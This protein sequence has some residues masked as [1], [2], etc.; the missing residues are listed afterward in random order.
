[1]NTRFLALEGNFNSLQRTI[2]GAAVATVAALL[3]VVGAIVAASIIALVVF[4]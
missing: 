1:M 3:G 2:I 4:L